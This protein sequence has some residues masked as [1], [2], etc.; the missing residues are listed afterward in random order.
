MIHSQTVLGC[1]RGIPRAMLGEPGCSL[2]TLKSFTSPLCASFPSTRT[3][4][5]WVAAVLSSSKNQRI[6]LPWHLIWIWRLPVRHQDVHSGVHHG[7]HT[8]YSHTFTLPLTHCPVQ[9][10]LVTPLNL[11]NTTVTKKHAW[12]TLPRWPASSTFF[13]A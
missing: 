13:A 5:A 7:N 6:P 1:C 4:L 8:L 3:S 10:D 2:W 9:E 11:Q 12:R